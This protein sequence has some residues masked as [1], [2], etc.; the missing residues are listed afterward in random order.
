[1]ALEAWADWKMGRLE[2]RGW[3]NAI[4]H[5]Y[6]MRCMWSG[7][8]KFHMFMKCVTADSSLRSEHGEGALQKFPESASLLLAAPGPFDCAQDDRGGM[9]SCGT[10]EAMP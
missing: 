10:A 4:P 1:M 7:K 2:M 5:V 9:H 8:Y 6:Q 3:A